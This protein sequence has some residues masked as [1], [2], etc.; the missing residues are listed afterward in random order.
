[1]KKLLYLLL[2]NL[3]LLGQIDGQD[4]RIKIGVMGFTYGNYNLKYERTVAPDITLQLQIG[5]RP[6]GQS[7]IVN[8]LANVLDINNFNEDNFKSRLRFLSV[9]PEFR[10]Y[11]NGLE[12]QKGFY[13]GA[14]LEY[15]RFGLGGEYTDE[16]KYETGAIMHTYGAGINMGVQWIV[17]ERF[18]IDWFIL[19]IGFA[20]NSFTFYYETDDPDYNVTDTINEINE[21]TGN[22]PF[23]DKILPI[24]TDGNRL[25]ANIPGFSFIRMR[26]GLS[27]GYAF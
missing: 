14:N 12:N 11:I 10:Y 20:F 27:F 9:I 25:E 1:M 4:N 21:T 8:S 6:V 13:V 7:W 16:F 3:L 15:S 2:F 17:N 23:V 22:I 24:S 5:L 19:G 26:T 18:V